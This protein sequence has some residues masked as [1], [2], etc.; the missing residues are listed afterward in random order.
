MNKN[1]TQIEAMR[2]LGFTDEEIKQVLDDDRRIDKGEKLFELNAEQ[3][4]ASKQARKTTRAPT[5]Y[6]LDNTAGKRS[7]KSDKAKAELIKLITATLQEQ[8]ACD[9]LEIL[10][11]EREIEFMWMRKKY[12]ITLSAPRT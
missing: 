10:N 12:K 8:P 2:K 1:S 5:A 7:K 9:N 11:P 6:K 4:Q 3:E